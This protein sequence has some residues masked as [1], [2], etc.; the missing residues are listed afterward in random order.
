MFSSHDQIWFQLRVLRGTTSES[1]LAGLLPIIVVVKQVWARDGV[2]GPTRVVE[3]ETASRLR[4]E[5]ED[6][7]AQ[8]PAARTADCLYYKSHLVLGPVDELAFSPL[9]IGLAATLLGPDVL[10]W[11]SNVPIKDA[12]TQKRFTP[13][14]DA[15]YWGLEPPDRA[16]TVWVALTDVGPENGGVQYKLGSH[17]DGQR[18]HQTE[19][20]ADV[21]LRRG[22]ETAVDPA[23]LIAIPLAPGEATAHHP[24]TVHASG[25]NP[26]SGPRIGVVLVYVASDV[27][28]PGRRD[29]AQVVC[30]GNTGHGF[31]AEERLSTPTSAAAL[32][33][34]AEAIEAMAGRVIAPPKKDPSGF[35]YAHQDSKRL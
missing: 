11:D 34:H 19:A 14:Q 32:A 8:L 1:A 25:P 26:T 5:L 4:R 3:P 30:G 10:L 31:A 9:A 27:T 6:Q 29:T 33:A 16:V 22:Q 15:T 2:V 28:T 35:V 23:E 13:H 18:L 24:F 7:I 21:M 17:L 12:G 20:R